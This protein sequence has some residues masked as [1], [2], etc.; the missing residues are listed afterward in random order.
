MNLK[1]LCAK[2]T[3]NGEGWRS[4]DKRF[5]RV[6]FALSSSSWSDGRVVITIKKHTARGMLGRRCAA[7]SASESQAGFHCNPPTHH[8]LTNF[9][10]ASAAQCEGWQK[11][12]KMFTSVIFALVSSSWSD[13]RVVIKTKQN[14]TKKS[15]ELAVWGLSA[16]CWYP[17]CK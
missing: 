9:F 8:P 15:S 1:H 7:S 6:V 13:G 10:L 14:K 11:A 2:T 17:T 5:T 3:P 4:A 12:D 16:S